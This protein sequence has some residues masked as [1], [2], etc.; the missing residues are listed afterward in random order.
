MNCHSQVRKES[1]LLIDLNES[2]TSGKSIP[3][4]RVHDLP[5]YVY[6]N[7]SAHVSR[8]IGCVSCHGR[9]DQ[10]DVVRQ[11]E[12]LSMSWCLQCHRDPDGH[13]RPKDKVTEM[14]WVPEEVPEVLHARLREEY[15][16]KPSTSCNTCH[17]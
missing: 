11:V 9:V 4:V 2:Y 13:L 3:W 5:D 17:R 14:D 6:F 12:P 8:G 7:H 15:D 1:E 16:I 10:M